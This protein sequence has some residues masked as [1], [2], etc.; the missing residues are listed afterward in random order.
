MTGSVKPAFSRLAEGEP[1]AQRPEERANVL[2]ERL[3]LLERGEVPA[4]RHF[5]PALH[6]EEALGPF[7]RGTGSAELLDRREVILLRVA[8]IAGR[9]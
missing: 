7:A 1:R 4:T 5:R 6:I 9:L 3:R 2:G 8:G